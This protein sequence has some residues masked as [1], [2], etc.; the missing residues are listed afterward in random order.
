MA[1]PP[2]KAGGSEG[3]S[4]P[5]EAWLPAELVALGGTEVVVGT[6][7]LIECGNQVEESLAAAL[8]AER[9]LLIAALALA[10]P[11]RSDTEGVGGAS[12]PPGSPQGP[13]TETSLGRPPASEPRLPLSRRS[14]L[15]SAPPWAAAIHPPPHVKP[16]S[17][18]HSSLP[19]PHSPVLQKRPSPPASPLLI[20]QASRAV[21][22]DT[23]GRGGHAQGLRE[24][25]SSYLLGLT[26]VV[27]GGDRASRTWGWP[28][29]QNCLNRCLSSP[30]ILQ[31]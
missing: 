19:P 24:G 5:V 4:Y 23:Q 13:G 11:G 28:S 12:S 18:Q 26:P 17:S 6:E 21:S 30:A 25:C 31:E 1:G 22:K 29:W 3:L 9:P 14:V 15:L 7:G 20:R 8:V 27:W 16:G 2:W 10:E